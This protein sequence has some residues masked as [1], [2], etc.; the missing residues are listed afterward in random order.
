MDLYECCLILL[1]LFF[2]F[3]LLLQLC[4]LSVFSLWVLRFFR[5]VFW[6]RVHLMYGLAFDVIGVFSLDFVNSWFCSSLSLSIDLHLVR[7]SSFSFAESFDSILFMKI[8]TMNYT[9]AKECK[10]ENK[11]PEV[12]DILFNHELNMLSFLFRLSCMFGVF[13][14]YY[15]S[16]FLFLCCFV[17]RGKNEHR[18][19]DRY[20]FLD[21]Y[22]DFICDFVFIFLYF[23]FIFWFAARI[24]A[25]INDINL[26]LNTA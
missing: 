20:S 16:L 11:D 12:L 6:L 10:R 4:F 9:Y 2:L 17:I 22:Y 23:L 1:Y 19:I 8:S 13:C 7:F 21:Y 15:S 18:R 25:P 3:V 14:F 26:I 24:S 5:S